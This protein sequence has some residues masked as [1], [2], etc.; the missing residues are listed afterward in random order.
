MNAPT[1]SPVVGGITLA[2]IEQLAADLILEGRPFRAGAGLTIEAQ[3]INTGRW[4]PINL[5]G[6]SGVCQFTDIGAR[7]AVLAVI[8]QRVY[9]HRL[10]E[11]DAPAGE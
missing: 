8:Q 1:P 11:E 7:D 9:A 3:V 10:V 2:W 6:Q 5:E 4:L